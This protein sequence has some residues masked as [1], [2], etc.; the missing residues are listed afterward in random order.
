M[1]EICKYASI[2]N[3]PQAEW[4]KNMIVISFFFLQILYFL[5]SAFLKDFCFSLNTKYCFD[6]EVY[7]YVDF[8]GL[9][10]AEHIVHCFNLFTL[11]LHPWKVL[12]YRIL[13]YFI[14]LSARCQA[15]PIHNRCR[16][17]GFMLVGAR[18]ASA[19]QD[20]IEKIMDCTFWSVR[21]D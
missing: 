19:N 8:F 15:L 4:R 21:N 17:A 16:Y 13:F 2:Y 18:I 20:G 14:F 1:V 5:G 3:N 9:N 12:F 10:D 6:Q 11:I 7:V